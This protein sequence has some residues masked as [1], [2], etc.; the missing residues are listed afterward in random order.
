MTTK[1]W[2]AAAL[3]VGGL[4]YGVCSSRPGG[5]R[6]PDEKLAK[7][8]TELCDIA[9]SNMKTPER[10]V[11][12]LGRYL[13]DHNLIGDLGS[14]VTMIER[15]DDDGA[16]DARARLARQ[17]LVAPLRACERVWAEFAE[18]VEDDPDARALV[19]R[20]AA[21]L[22]RTLEILFGSDALDLRDLPRQLDR[23]LGATLPAM[24]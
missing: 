20:F 10:G 7:E 18:A 1:A 16:H 4:A 17:R 8:L 5:G 9:R 13:A 2:L 6:A 24:R 19:D 12:G 15:I 14:T 11:R 21:R 23:V 3:V 22:N